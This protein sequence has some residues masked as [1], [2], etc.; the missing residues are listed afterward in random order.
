MRDSNASIFHAER[1]TDASSAIAAPPQ[2][3]P[4][5]CTALSWLYAEFTNSAYNSRVVFVRL[6]ESVQTLYAE[7]LDQLRTADAEMAVAGVKG[8]FVSKVIRG[9]TYWYEQRSEGAAKRQI[10]LGRESPEL[11]A[12]MESTSTQRVLAGG[13]E[14][15]R[16]ELVTMLEAGGM[17][18][19]SAAIGVVLRVLSGASV[20]R[21]GGVLVGTQA[22][23]CIANML[24]VAFEKESLRTADVDV[25]H[26]T[27]IPLGLSALPDLAMLARL[28]AQDPA[29]FEVPGIDSREPSTSFKVRGRD[30]RVDFLTSADKRSRSTKPV[31]LRHLR[32][33]AQPLYGLD[34]VIESSVDAAVIVGSGV[35][36]NVPTP[37]RFAFHKLWVSTERPASEAAKAR[38]DLRQAEQLLDV[39]VA[40]RPGDLTSAWAALQSRRSL[41][42]GARSALR[43]I[44]PSVRDRLIETLKMAK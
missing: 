16:R 4:G 30:L 22:F 34:Y 13:D 41:L 17:F 6:P 18:R 7:L 20:F 21:A 5:L 28:R 27:S 11:L 33:A 39:L 8:T 44:A 3:V 35:R 24:G 37:A 43:K 23:T 36:V 42:R 10:Y 32:V 12:Q 19:E 15:R 29:F 31:Y 38:K 1:V 25:A 9:R 2:N 14:R 26:D 40:D